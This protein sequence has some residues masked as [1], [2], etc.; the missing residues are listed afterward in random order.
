MTTDI[1]RLSQSQCGPFLTR[2][3]PPGLQQEQNTKGAICGAGTAY[4]S[5]ASG[6]LIGLVFL[7]HQFLFCRS[8]FV[9]LFFLFVWPLYCNVL[10][11]PLVLVSSNFSYLP[12]MYKIISVTGQLYQIMVCGIYVTMDGKGLAL[13]AQVDANQTIAN[14]LFFKRINV[15]VLVVEAIL[16]FRQIILDLKRKKRCLPLF[17]YMNG[18]RQTWIVNKTLCI[19]NG[20]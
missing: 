14:K 9:L 17:V 3:L 10:L 19:K 8:L 11:L 12:L 5:G 16:V 15:L 2:D 13:T 1:F 20:R 6:F 7:D 4:P 18:Q